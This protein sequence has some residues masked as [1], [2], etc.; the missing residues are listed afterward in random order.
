MQ[1][2]RPRPTGATASSPEDTSPSPATPAKRPA[3]VRNRLVVAVAVV[4]AAVAGAAAPGIADATGRLSDSQQAVTGS[5]QL[6]EALALAHALA[7][8]RDAETA[9][10]AAGGSAESS[11]A[12]HRDRVDRRLAELRPE[13][14]AALAAALGAVAGARETARAEG[15]TAL[16][17]HQAYARPLAQLHALAERFAEQ[18][19]GRAPSGSHALAELDT[20]VAQTSAARGLLGAALA[21]P[22]GTKITTLDPVTGATVTRYAEKK[23]DRAQRRTLTEAAREAHLRSGTAL[24]EFRETAPEKALR[25]YDSAVTG[26]GV[27]EAEQLLGRLT[28]EPALSAAELALDRGRTDA[29]LRARIELMRGAESALNVRRS[30]D[31]AALRDEDVTALE[32]RIALAGVCLLLAAGFAMATFRSLTRPLA[33]LRLGSARLAGEPETEEPVRFT[34][35][36]DEFAQIVASVNAL[37]AHAVALHERLGTLEGERRHLIGQRQ[38]LAEERE[39][40]RGKLAESTARLEGMEH[41]I[42]ATFVSLALRTLGL[43]ERQ[44][45]AIERL[46]EREQDPDRLATLFK[47]DHFATLMRRHSENLLILAGADHRQ[48]DPGPVPLVDVVRAAVSEI[49]RYERVRITALPAHAHIVGFAADDLSHLLAELLDNA[50]AFS[51]PDT[52]VEISGQLLENGDLML[53]AVDE[54]IG[55]S[56][57]RLRV[58]NARLVGFD[59][60]SPYVRAEGEDPEGGLGL[61]LYV[62]GRLAHRHG[63][64]VQLREQKEG[65]VAA[66]L[67]LPKAVLTEAPTTPADAP[68]P[69]AAS[70][71]R[72]PGSEAEANSNALYGRSDTTAG[73]DLPAPASETALAPASESAAALASEGAPVPESGPAPEPAEPAESAAGDTP[74]GPGDTPSGPG[75]TPPGASAQGDDPLIAAAERAVRAS[76]E[77]TA[78]EPA[79]APEPA[80]EPE[81]TPA[82]VP[83]PGRASAYVRQSAPESDPAYGREPAPEPDPAHAPE[84]APASRPASEPAPRSGTDP[85]AIGPDRHERAE[86]GATAPS[87]APPASHEEQPPAAAE[88]P[89]SLRE[90]QQPAPHQERSAPHQEQP[91]APYE[92]PPAPY[93]T[94]LPAMGPEPAPWDELTDKGLPR[95]TPKAAEPVPVP[96]PRSGGVDP[97]E[98]RRRLGGFHRGA[99][100]GRRDADAEIAGETG[101]AQGP[102]DPVEEGTS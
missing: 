30:K 28:D 67:V 4:A 66:V 59:P 29:V 77:A 99:L 70:A 40:L 27:T 92:A 60:E 91:S 35:R 89:R 61:G 86:D 63:V 6:A 37:H 88:Q 80:P 12:E 95:R 85:Y 11:S 90:E 16:Q 56:A 42:H 44:L 51:P 13:A 58:L 3:R 75:D 82:P 47:L 19:P 48:Q 20:A 14:P 54:G 26:D 43:I 57:G 50:A 65:G 31:L 39:E 15:T 97:Q 96:Q 49:E 98:L 41:S 1:K 53:S 23:A 8:E 73:Q 76:E 9:R 69:S 52:P 102:G 10:L 7:E 79:P 94:P 33:V 100:A 36:N 81:R 46:E 62:A 18:L 68:A 24:A 34:G 87:D 45:G 101:E 38:M 55:A 74:P 83:V 71:V 21:V 64:R 25:S 17:A 78:A 2:K 93:A 84:P 32:I 5:E 72:F 22:R